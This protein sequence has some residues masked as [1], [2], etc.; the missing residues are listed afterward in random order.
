MRR[1][2]DHALSGPSGPVQTSVHTSRLTQR[3]C[4]HRPDL[5][6]AHTQCGSQL[7]PFEKTTNRCGRCG[8]CGHL[9]NI[10][11]SSRPDPSKQVRTVRTAAGARVLPADRNRGRHSEIGRA[12]V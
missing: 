11:G 5:S 9:S 10:K 1:P 8:Q 7:L 4:P 12:H 2:S 3:G 6:H